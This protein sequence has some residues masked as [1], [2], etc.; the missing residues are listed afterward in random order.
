MSTKL[1]GDE[2]AFEAFGRDQSMYDMTAI[3]GYF[4]TDDTV[5]EG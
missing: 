1:N 3:E 4:S 2:L 5:R